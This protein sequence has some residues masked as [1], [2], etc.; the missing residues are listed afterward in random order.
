MPFSVDAVNFNILNK[1]AKKNQVEE[2]ITLT[3]S[4]GQDEAR[5][6]LKFFES[7]LDLNDLDDFKSAESVGV[8]TGSVEYQKPF[9]YW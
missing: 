7:N 1:N 9:E 8:W 3:L 5:K 6:Y 4:T 2:N